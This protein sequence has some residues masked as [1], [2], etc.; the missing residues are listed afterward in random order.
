[1]LSASTAPVTAVPPINLLAVRRSV[2][3]P[4]IGLLT[5]AS[6]A[7]MPLLLGVLG[8]V[9]ASPGYP[10]GEFTLAFPAW[11]VIV[12]LLH[13]SVAAFQFVAAIKMAR[14]Q[15]YGL[16]ISASIC[17]LLPCGPGT[18]FFSIGTR[19]L[20]L[21]SGLNWV[22]GIPVGIW[23]LVVLSRPEVRAAFRTSQSARPARKT[24][25]PA[26]VVLWVLALVFAL[27]CVGPGVVSWI[28]LVP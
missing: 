6:L 22:I 5:V 18:L 13:L 15:W 1:M 4:A 27:C 20:G 2:R 9:M 16:A 7:S 19:W 21:F 17:S 24:R 25:S 11:F 14:L 8:A 23:A 3:G 28:V 26:S 12:P 10:F